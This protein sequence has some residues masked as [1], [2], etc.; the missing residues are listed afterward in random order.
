MG[1]RKSKLSLLWRN[2]KF[3]TRRE[4]RSDL[5]DFV[6]CRC[7]LADMLKGVKMPNI[8]DFEETARVLAETDV[9]IARFGDGEFTLI[10]GRGIPFQRADAQLA[11]RLA[12]LLAKP[13]PNCLV[14]VP[15]LC[16]FDDR[17][18]VDHDNI[19]WLRYM[20]TNGARLEAR[21]NAAATYFDSYVSLFSRSTV[22]GYDVGG[23]FDR[24]RRIWAGKDVLVVCGK[25]IFD[26]FAHDIFDNARS[27]AF[28][29]GP[30]R[31]AFSDYDALLARVKAAANG[32][33]VLIVLGPTATVM[34]A[35]LA[36]AGVRALDLGHLAKAYDAFRSGADTD[37]KARKNFYKAD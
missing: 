24:L 18:F 19:W 17:R 26:G 32:R 37:A 10:D 16:W 3:L 35:D 34:A 27:V 7:K 21:M 33:I 23:M 14:G 11:A 9:S 25:G 22:P 30:R 20:K 36:A 1:K 13:P 15:R 12:E 8:L 2:L 5:V 31:D 29:H 6:G 4:L 28:V